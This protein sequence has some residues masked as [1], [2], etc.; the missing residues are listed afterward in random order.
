MF[1][2]TNRSTLSQVLFAVSFLSAKAFA[3]SCVAPPPPCQVI[4]QTPVVFLGTVTEVNT[5]QDGTQPSARMNIDR[6]FKGDLKNTVEVADDLLCGG[7]QVQLGRQYVIYAF[8]PPGGALVA[9][10]CSRSRPAED[11]NE[12]LD[13]LKQYLSGR[14]TT[15][16]D[17]TVR[18]RPDEPEDSKLGAEG[19]VPMK[20]VQVTL[21]S[22]AGEFHATT[23][24]VGRYSFSD[25]PPG[26]Y[27]VGADLSGYR[28]NWSPENLSLAAN[29]CVEANLLMKVD[30]RVRGTVRDE[31]GEPASGVLVQMASTDPQLERFQQPILLDISDED[32]HYA[33]DGIPPGNYYLGV[34]IV[35]TPTKE[36]PY[37]VIY[38]PNTTDPSR[39]AR[40]DFFTGA[41]V[42]N[43]DLTVPHRL[44]RVTIRGRI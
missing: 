14:V 16:I 13:F 6:A 9:S 17:G 8:R 39:A 2:R 23:S 5:A 24:S 38:Y 44:T 43:L 26:T 10:S 28:L 25:L 41:A 27:T 3:C 1:G 22:D 4:G 42:E 20:D 7:P 29:G 35:D 36:S 37:P 40:I 15:H 30:R 12:D 18:L 31:N 34:N 19:R 32:G 11:A 21:S 33:I